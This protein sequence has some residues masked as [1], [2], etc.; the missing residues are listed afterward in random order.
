M[1]A[2]SSNPCFT[3]PAEPDGDEDEI[4]FQHEFG[5]GNRP[6]P[7]VD[8]RADDADGPAFLAFDAQGCGLELAL[9]AL[10][11]AR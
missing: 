3:G 4:G 9:G 2:S 10:G 11:L 1:P 6:T 8:A 7:V 5:A